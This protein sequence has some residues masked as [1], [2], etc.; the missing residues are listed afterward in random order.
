VSL[1]NKRQTDINMSFCCFYTKKS[2]EIE[3]EHETADQYNVVQ[4]ESELNSDSPQ[5]VRKNS[6]RARMSV[7]NDIDREPNYYNQNTTPTYVQTGSGMYRN[8]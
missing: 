5:F 7:K 6:K 4:E 8:M 3:R 1:W 2:K